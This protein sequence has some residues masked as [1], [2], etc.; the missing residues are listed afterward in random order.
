MRE[1]VA[2]V[3]QYGK[4]AQED[5]DL[6]RRLLPLAMGRA[7]AFPATESLSSQLHVSNTSLF[8]VRAILLGFAMD[9]GDV[10]KDYKETKQKQSQHGKEYDQ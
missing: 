10:G 9:T 7:K 5:P 6:A 2:I 4:C 3:P 8:S 1:S